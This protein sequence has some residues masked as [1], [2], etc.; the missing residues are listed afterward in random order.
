MTKGS[1]NRSTYWRSLN[2]LENTPEF[3]QFMHREFPVAASEFPDG[4]SRRRWLQLMSAS[5]ALAGF[6]GC[7]Y[8]TEQFA[9]LVGRSD[10]RLPG[11]PMMFA[12]SFE[13]AGRAVHLLAGNVDGR[14][15]K[16]EGNAQ[17]PL[18]AS[19]DPSPFNDGKES[20]FA[21]AGTDAYTQACILQ[22]YD[23]DRCD[24][25]LSRSAAGKEA[26]ESNWDTFERS[27]RDRLE[28]IKANAGASLAIL[29]PPTRSPSLR[30]MLSEIKTLFPQ[31]TFGRH[32]MVS[33]RHFA[34]GIKLAAGRYGEALWRFE[35]AAVICSL[36]S[37]IFS[38][39][40]AGM[41]YARQYS[42]GRDPKTGS[43]NRLYSIEGQYSMTGASADSRLSIPTHQIGSFAVELEKR[44]DAKIA[45]GAT[46]PEAKG[47]A[48]W[49]KLDAAARIERTLD[50]LSSDLVAN[51]GKSAV[52]AGRHQPADVQAVVWRINQKLGNVGKTVDILDIQD[53]QEMLGA[54]SLKEF[55]DK[56]ATGKVEDLWILGGN[57]VYG[58]AEE[59]KLGEKIA[60]VA[61]SV[62]LADY[63]DE[64]AAFCRSIVPAA[65]P[66]ECWSDVMGAD[67]GYGIGQPQILPLLGGKSV[68]ELLAMLVQAEDRD[69]QNYVRST[70]GVVAGNKLG[71]QQ[72]KKLLHDGYLESVAAKPLS[73]KLDQFQGEV[74][75]K[76]AAE[77]S[78]V[79]DLEIVILPS[80]S[81]YDGR[82]ANNGWL[83][84]LP[85]SVSKLV[86]DNAALVSAELAESKRLSQGDI[87][88]VRVNGRSIELPVF[89]V[90]GINPTTIVTQ[91]GYG[92]KSAGRVG[93]DVGHDVTPLLASDSSA[94]ITGVEI[95]STTRPYKLATTQDHFSIDQGGLVETSKRAVRLV[96]EGTYEQY[97]H[98]DS[99]AEHMGIHHPPLESL[100]TP[101]DVAQG[102]AWAMTIDLNKCIGCNSCVIACQAEN[103]VPV[104]GKEQVARGRE[105][106]WL[107]I[108]RYFQ[109]DPSF[110]S[111]VNDPKVVFQPVA[112]VHCE[113]APCEQ[114]C[115]V[116][117]T[118]H[119]ED[120]INAMAYNRCVGT[121][122]C[123]NNCPYKVRRFNYFNYNKP[124]G[125]YYGWIDYR[126]DANRKLQQ[127]VLNP[128]VTVRGR[129]VME[130]CTYCIQ[131]VQNGKIAA[132]ADGRE[133]KDG[134][135]KTACQAACPSQAIVFG[136]RND[137]SSRVAILQKDPR[138][139]AML[140]ELNIKPRTLYLARLRNVHPRLMTQDQVDHATGGHGGHG[141]DDHGHEDKAHGDTHAAAE[142]QHGA[143][144]K[145]A[146]D[147]KPAEAAAH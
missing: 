100:W 121:R 95:A 94:V 20:S 109:G 50:V 101:P 140:E 26:T 143:E 81:V 45:G 14:P 127:L 145:P 114:V 146:G 135:I 1:D 75:V 38:Q 5:L 39:E 53:D 69:P 131:R 89:I 28:V 134:D 104:V 96:R 111:G 66:L 18:T 67:G 102:H 91:M 108:D 126:E 128:E 116:A 40:P 31:A 133:L 85:Q 142:G 12:T 33:D 110:K 21:T 119:T 137:A 83:Q 132:K 112:C 139:Y 125:Y 42:L 44:I 61:H 32:S 11:I 49:D 3:E 36:D 105:M 23:P 122:Y 118:V 60:A 8:Q 34:A 88:V 25:L 6:A 147:A 43:M 72:W 30:R 129:G 58:A 123:A 73:V 62:Y 103:N 48:T 136:D 41:V 90:P 74:A 71:D 87:A 16:L 46:A 106:H 10:Q 117:A 141:H 27:V 37:D 65:H 84:E 13:W 107:R 138:A 70:A 47:E 9:A 24:Q 64:T 57:P 93:N 55:A 7:R 17:Y 120:G 92:R 68:L 54:V 2:E 80:E 19:V 79:K 78:Q 115:P 98:D 86:W 77:I 35:K 63:V 82:F 76:P 22:L 59:L 97:K 4:I 113:M 56:L 29:V 52:I 144:T 124:Y 99:F 130:K 15:I 51:Q